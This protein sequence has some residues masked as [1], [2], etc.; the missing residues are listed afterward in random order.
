MGFF[1]QP[2][3]SFSLRILHDL[4]GWGFF[5]QSTDKQLSGLCSRHVIYGRHCSGLFVFRLFVFHRDTPN[6]MPDSQI[7]A[8]DLPN[9]TPDFAHPAPD[10]ANPAPDSQIPTGGGRWIS[11][12]IRRWILEIR[13]RISQF[14]RRICQ[15]RHR[16]G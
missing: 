12:E 2:G 8:P 7:P 9:P 6:P 3:S 16:N 15:I 5:H 1:D 10:F 4:M 11:I 14:R 13:R